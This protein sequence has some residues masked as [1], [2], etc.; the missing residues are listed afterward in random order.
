MICEVCGCPAARWLRV[1][2]VARRFKC[3]TKKVRRL[4]KRGELEGVRF[5]GEWR[6]DH[7]SLDDYVRKDSLEAGIAER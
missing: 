4:I 5:G 6:V 7:D 2:T 3:S 1:S